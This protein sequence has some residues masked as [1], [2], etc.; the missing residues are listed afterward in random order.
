MRIGLRPEYT[1]EGS[2]AIVI[3][4]LVKDGMNERRHYNGRPSAK[5]FFQPCISGVHLCIS[6]CAV[7]VDTRLDMA[8]QY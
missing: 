5:L 6:E 2:E 1:V 3:Q 4:D 7:A 8:S